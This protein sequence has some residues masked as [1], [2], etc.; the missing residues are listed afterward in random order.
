MVHVVKCDG[1]FLC[2]PAGHLVNILQDLTPY[3]TKEGI[4]YK[5]LKSAVKKEKLG[6]AFIHSAFIK[7]NPSY[8]EEMGYI[9]FDLMEQ[10]KSEKPIVVGNYGESLGR[11]RK[12]LNP[13]QK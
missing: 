1:E 3:K 13:I 5:V 11:L 9:D 12:I 8:V 2:V 4:D 6:P 10:N 7:S